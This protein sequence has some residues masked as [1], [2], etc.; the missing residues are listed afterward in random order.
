M[1]WA[2]SGNGPRTGTRKERRG[3]CVLVLGLKLHGSCAFPSAASTLRAPGSPAV[4]SGVRG[5]DSA[6]W[7]VRLG[8]QC[9][10]H[11]VRIASDQ[12]K[13]CS[14][15]LVR[16]RAALLPIAQSAKR[17]MVPDGKFLLSQF[18]RPADDFR[19]RRPLHSVEVG[20]GQR[21]GVGVSP[22]SLLDCFRAH[23]SNRS[24]CNSRLA[25]FALVSGLK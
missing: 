3:R 18:Q 20:A 13:V 7:L 24:G 8:I 10:V 5:N 23:W 21:L 9:P 11:V 19:L 2:M 15:R 14:R 12:R 22:S 6:W 16:F 4:G 1:Y 17:D 25:H